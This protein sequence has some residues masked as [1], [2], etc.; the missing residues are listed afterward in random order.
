MRTIT[1]FLFA[2]SLFA[3][4]GSI[5]S[6]QATIDNEPSGV[7]AG[8]KWDSW[9]SMGVDFVANPNASGINTSANVL[10]FTCNAVA[11]GG[12]DWDGSDTDS[13][14]SFTLSSSNCVIKM[15]VYKTVISKTI[16]KIEQGA[17]T[18]EVPLFN[19]KINEWEEMSFD[20]TPYIGMT[21]TRISL[22]PDYSVRTT[23]N[24]S[25]LDNISF[26]SNNPNSLSAIKENEVSV[27][28]NPANGVLNI[29]AKQELSQVVL[30]NIVGV[31]VKT[32]VVNGLSSTIDLSDVA[33]GAYIVTIKQANGATSAQ[34]VIIN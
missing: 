2:A 33:K 27:Y 20:F 15:M 7:G 4:V 14:P 13:N 28:P 17:L 12:N 1:K 11:N 19:N 16:F 8:Y 32:V 9:G 29:S 6:A 24:I 23:Q 21:V 18:H 22:F 5:A 3:A 25:Y 10:K 30:S 26:N 34:K 31:A